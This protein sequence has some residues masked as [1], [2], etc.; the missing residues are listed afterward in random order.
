MKKALVLAIIMFL[1]P[2]AAW[3]GCWDDFGQIESMGPARQCLELQKRVRDILEKK[4]PCKTFAF[5]WETKTPEGAAQLGYVLFDGTIDDLW[6]V[7]I[8]KYPGSKPFIRWETW[9]NFSQQDILGLDSAVGL[10]LKSDAKGK[11]PVPLMFGP[12]DF[13]EKYGPRR[14]F[15]KAIF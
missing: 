4:M 1:G 9:D 8:T 14:E 13:V 11:G 6:R 2:A 10:D 7:T 15:K 12:R 5:S 3:S